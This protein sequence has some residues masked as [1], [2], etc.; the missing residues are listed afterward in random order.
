MISALRRHL[1]TLL[2]AGVILGTFAASLYFSAEAR[3]VALEALGLVFTFFTT[4]FILETTVAL[5][6]LSVVL[7][8]NNHRLEKEKD[9]WVEMEVPVTPKADQPA[10][11]TPADGRQA[12]G[13]AV[14]H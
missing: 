13:S 4:P 1:F 11:E 3:Q 2:P 6:S 10:T 7:M 8:I 9:E 12:G 14:P 5:I